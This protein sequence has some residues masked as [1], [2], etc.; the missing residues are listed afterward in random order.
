MAKTGGGP[1]RASRINGSNDLARRTGATGV[2]DRKR[3]LAALANPAERPPDRD[4]RSPAASGKADG[5]KS[6]QRLTVSLKQS[7]NYHT[8]PALL[9]RFP[10]AAGFAVYDGRQRVA[11]LVDLEPVAWFGF[12]ADDRPLG[13][14]KSKA[15]FA[16]VNIAFD[17]KSAA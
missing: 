13:P 10:A 6:L 14:C 2:F 7:D 1:G 11:S 17:G 5:A 8:K 9:K 4:M 12:D 3:V 16:A 15:A